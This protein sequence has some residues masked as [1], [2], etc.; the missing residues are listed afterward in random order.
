MECF[1][2]ILHTYTCQHYLKTGLQKGYET[3]LNIILAGKVLLVKKLIN[4]EL[5]GIF[6]S[7]FP[8]LYSFTLHIE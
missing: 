7:N 6:S 2:K 8:G 3:S 1:D 4:P 5:H